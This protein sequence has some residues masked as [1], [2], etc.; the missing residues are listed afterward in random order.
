M[1][2]FAETIKAQELHLMNAWMHRDSGAFRKLAARDCMMIF[3]SN[4]PELLDRPSFLEAMTKDFRCL[5]FR[6][7]ESVVRRYKRAAWYSAGADLEMK[8]GAKDWTG[9]FLITG[10]WYKHTIGGWKLAERSIAMLSEDETIADR[11]R[12]LQ[13]WR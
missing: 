1:S 13:M 9:R 3:G 7:G 12:R 10:L 5:G 4:P 8:V 6:M 2:D 11:I